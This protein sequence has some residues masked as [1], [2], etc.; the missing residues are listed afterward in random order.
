ME[1][2]KETKKLKKPV[3]HGAADVPVIM[4][5]E[6]LECGAASLAMVLAYYGKWLPLEQVRFDCGVSRDGS[7]A[8]NILKA[9]RSYGLAAK[10]YRYEPNDL[11]RDGKFPCI[12]H[13][14]FNH[15]VVLDGFR[16]NKAILNDPA[17]GKYAVSLKTFDDSFT[18]ICLLF[19]PTEDFT[20]GGKPP[21]VLAYAKKRLKGAGSAVA[22]AAITALITA[23]TGVISPAFS[24]VFVDRLLTGKN[25]EW[26]I[27]FIIGLSLL[28]ILQLVV[29][30][31]NAVYSLK[32][33]G[34][35]AM[36]GST[37]FMWKVLR[38]PM[39]FFSQRMAGDIQGR[40][41]SNASI[42]GSLVNTFAPLALNAVMMV[43]YLV[44]M[45]RYSL[46]LTVIGILSVL[47]NLVFSNIISKKRINITRVQMRDSGKLAGATVAGIE[48][49][50][51]IKAS[52]AEN[53]FFEKWAGYQAS[54]NTQQVKFQKLNQ[55]LGQLPALVSSVCNTA[56]LM[57]GVYLAM[58]GRFTVGMI[59]AFQGFLG[60]FISPATSLISAGQSLQE[61][62]TEME[63]IEDVMRYPTDVPEDEPVSD[64]C[65]YDKL[66]GNIE[67]KNVTFGYSRLAEPL[68]ENFNL[69]LKTGSRVAFVGPSGCGKSTLSKLI[70]GLYKPWS[71]EILFDGKKIS[72]IDRSVFTGSLAVVDQD[73]I[74]FEDTIANN[75]KMW[76]NSI[77]DF[78]MIMAARDA[79]LHEDIMQRE[80]GYQYKMTEGGKD[81][82]GGQRQRMEIARVLAQDPTI[83]ILDEATSA[84]DA[85]TEYNVVISIKD[86][87]ITCIV[88]AH[89]L[90]TIRDCDEIIVMDNGRVAERGT[91]DE[92]M[93]K[94]GM[95]AE[96][97]TNE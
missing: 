12:I 80:G 33:N 26:F 11:R 92:L 66:S 97:V 85:K 2:V 91:H 48:M 23:I 27:P 61:M 3:T 34:K 21:S 95:Y 51:T 76:D 8:R 10:G 44:V 29:G 7:N 22:F 57:V 19:E 47:I 16:G 69:S 28:G 75:I 36:V 94:G 88:V 46:L 31:I 77:E 71:G 17:K 72:E 86:R 15:F 37:T 74:L 89:R 30:W 43:F 62:R 67:M 65:E 78:E 1:K 45:I 81:F 4:Q 35:L 32:I 24:R 49:I 58:Q 79:Q 55:L 84:L 96:L 5:M 59:M 83:I 70:S 93:K 50:E 90:S 54:A 52:G 41:S 25:P 20:P 18:G 56:V 6:A 42:A 87:G 38:M 82:S 39:E 13:W 64:N 14:N 73:I 53:G 40:Q 60:S 63:R 68:I 9:A